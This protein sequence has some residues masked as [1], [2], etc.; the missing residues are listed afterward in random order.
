MAGVIA[1]LASAAARADRKYDIVVW[2]STGFTGQLIADYLV[3]QP[4]LTWAIAGRNRGKLESV[5][6]DLA[7]A[8]KG[9]GNGNGNGKG[10]LPDILIASSSDSDMLAVLVKQTRVIISSVGPFVLHGEPL[11]AA[12]AN[13]GTDY[14][15]ITG[16]PGWVADMTERYDSKARQ[17]GALIISMCGFDCVPSDLGA[18]LV[19]SKLA[20]Q[21]TATRFIESGMESNGRPSGGSIASGLA[22]LGSSNVLRLLD[23]YLLVPSQ[24]RPIKPRPQEKDRFYPVY[25]S[26]FYQWTT[27]HPLTLVS[28]RVVRRSAALAAQAGQPYGNSFSYSERLLASSFLSALVQVVSIMLLALLGSVSFIR[29][30]IENFVPKPGTG[31]SAE[32]RANNWFHFRFYGEGEQSGKAVRVFVQGGDPGYTETSKIVS[33]CAIFLAFDRSKVAVKSGC[34]TPARVFGLPLIDR[35]NR[36]GITF[37]VL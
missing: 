23:P 30:F 20:E 12:C 9:N 17:S 10:K 2:G 27:V 35:L 13:Y 37:K 6:S 8:S 26:H 29:N 15:D 21:G 32:E 18:L 7:L 24:L 11:V 3:K 28:S 19:V 16:E 14:V 5:L 36:I 1:G 22:N 31:P 25:S 33:E 34:S 4:N